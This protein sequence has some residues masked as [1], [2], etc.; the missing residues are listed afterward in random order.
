MSTGVKPT[1]VY[2]GRGEIRD[3]ERWAHMNARDMDTIENW[4]YSARY[5]TKPPAPFEGAAMPKKV[6]GMVVYEV[7]D[8]EPH[9]RCCV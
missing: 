9:M 8:D 5:K 6:A 2:L 1:R 4:A 7:N 3:L